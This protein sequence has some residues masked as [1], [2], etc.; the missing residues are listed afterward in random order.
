M[1]MTTARK[2]I[3]DVSVT[4]W[5]HCLSR[6][7]R[8]GYLMGEGYDDRKQWIEDR[9]KLLASAFSISVGGFAI[10]DNH[11]HVLCRLDPE[12]ARRWSPQEVMRRWITVYPP[13][14]LAMDDPKVVK[15]WIDHQIQ[16]HQ[17]VEIL[18]ERLTNLG[19]F[20][21]A[22]KEPLSR[23]ANRNDGC[24]GAFWEA[25]FKSIAVLDTEALLATC[26]YIDLNP[27]AAG[28]ADTPETSPHTSIRQRLAHVKKQGKLERLKAARQGSVAGSKAAGNIEQGHWLVPIEDR[29]VYAKSKSQSAREGMLETFSLG[30]YLLLVD[31]TGRLFRSGKAR[32]DAGLQEVF[33]RLGTSVEYWNDRIKKMLSSRDLR[34]CYFASDASRVQELAHRRGQRHLANMS[35]QPSVG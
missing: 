6:C 17:R 19:W 18:R 15:M 30:S 21:K 23:L 28:I 13:A 25:R 16:D 34:G 5:Y 24:R 3:V 31:Y 26:A 10:L 29:R 8:G 22:L 20:M 32:M 12:D 1:L 2:N 27:L 4:R 7:V 35:P 14:T 11:L 9:L 33:D